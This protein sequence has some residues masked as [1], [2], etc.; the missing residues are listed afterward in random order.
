MMVKTQLIP[1]RSKYGVDTIDL[2]RSTLGYGIVSSDR[3]SGRGSS[4]LQ[5]VGNLML[6]C[7]NVKSTTLNFTLMNKRY[8]LDI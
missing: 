5:I 3:R 4:F 7:Y 6:Q 1:W 2:D 8:L